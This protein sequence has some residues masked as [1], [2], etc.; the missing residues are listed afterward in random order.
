M[1][2]LYCAVFI[3][4]REVSLPQLHAT[5]PTTIKAEHIHPVCTRTQSTHI[6]SMHTHTEHTYT[7]SI[8]SWDSPERVS[9][10]MSLPLN[11]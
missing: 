3:S 7:P 8:D 11:P 5:G 6:P 4:P 10:R 9:D 1:L 2:K